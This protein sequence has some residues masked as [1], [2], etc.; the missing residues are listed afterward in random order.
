[1]NLIKFGISSSREGILTL[2]PEYFTCMTDQV[3][4][5]G[6][7]ILHPQHS[8]VIGDDVR[9]FVV[10]EITEE[11]P[12][13]GD[14]RDKPPSTFRKIIYKKENIPGKV[15]REIGLLVTEEVR[16]EKNQIEKKTFLKF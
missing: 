10:K 14:W 6:D 12:C 13:R 2:F 1:M 8:K 3:L 4:S 15:L 9:T 11:R 7:V 16:N 5:E